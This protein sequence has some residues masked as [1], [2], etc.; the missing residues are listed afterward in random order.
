MRVLDAAV[1]RSSPAVLARRQS[2]A[3]F[4]KRWSQD[5]LRQ[6]RR[7]WGESDVA[8]IARALGRPPLSVYWKGRTIGLPAGLPQG[9]E[10]LDAAAKRTGFATKQLRAILRRAHVRIRPWMSRPGKPRTFGAVDPDAV[11]QAVEAFLEL[12]VVNQAAVARGLLGATLGL[13][14]RDAGH[15]PPPKK[16]A[17][18][19][20]PSAVIDRVIAARRGTETVRAAAIRVG[21]TRH[22][23]A[24]W[25]R[26]AGVPRGPGRL[27]YVP[28]A[29][30]DAL[31]AE[32]RGSKRSRAWTGRRWRKAA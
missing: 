18:W 6:L 3:R 17:R 25:L 7:L 5:D 14:L 15:A 21:V 1:R 19:R 29:T 11:D 32:R 28:R 31:V 2:E 8:E 27:W 22:S 16:R 10:S 26:A 9:T 4:Y 13:W 24:A 30:V 12:E 23:L 20:L